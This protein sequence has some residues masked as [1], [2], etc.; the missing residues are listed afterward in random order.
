MII[1]TFGLTLM[2]IILCVCFPVGLCIFY[3]L[4]VNFP[5]QLMANEMEEKSIPL[6]RFKNNNN[7]NINASFEYKNFFFSSSSSCVYFKMD[8]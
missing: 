6:I 1:I 3:G 8:S 7:N 5:A 4:I 2:I